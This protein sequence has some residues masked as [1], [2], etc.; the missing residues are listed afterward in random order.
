MISF[1][2]FNYG[3][4]IDAMKFQCGLFHFSKVVMQNERAINPRSNEM[5]NFLKA[6]LQYKQWQVAFG[7]QVT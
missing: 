3:S 7:P 2:R 1:V 6:V 5:K 4:N